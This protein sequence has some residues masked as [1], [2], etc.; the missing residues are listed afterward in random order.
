MKLGDVPHCSEL[1]R[2]SGLL[3]ET[4]AADPPV[5]A[6]LPDGHDD[7]RPWQGFAIA[8]TGQLEKA[9]LDKGGADRLYD[10]CEELHRVAL[11]KATRP[12]WKIF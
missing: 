10:K 5:S 7:A 4:P 9:N 2:A 8:Q 6:K 12:W 11:E 1:V 3:T